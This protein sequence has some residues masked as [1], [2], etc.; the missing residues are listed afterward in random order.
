MIIGIPVI[1]LLLFGYAINTDPKNLPAAL[2]VQDDSPYSRS[3]VRAMENSGYFRVVSQHTS[4]DTARD[5]L[6]HGEVQ[7]VLSIPRDFSRKL[8]RGERPQLLLEADATDPSA[9]ANAIV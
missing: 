7:F 2:V 4:E 6:E 8:A 3:L 5:M 9:A 1:Q